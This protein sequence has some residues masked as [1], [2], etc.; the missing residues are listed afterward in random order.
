MQN[1]NALAAALMARI[2]LHFARQSEIAEATTARLEQS[3]QDALR[4]QAGCTEMAKTLDR[5]EGK[6]LQQKPDI[7]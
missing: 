7:C 1:D 3:L 2:E 6:T 4:L 5:I